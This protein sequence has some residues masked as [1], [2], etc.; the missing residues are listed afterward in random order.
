MGD[1]GVV[2]QHYRVHGGIESCVYSLVAGLNNAGIVP[3]LIGRLNHPDEETGMAR[4]VQERF[5]RSLEFDFQPLWTD[6]LNKGSRF[7]RLTQD[8]SP[9]L[10]MQLPVLRLR[11]VYDFTLPLPLRVARGQYA[12]YWN[13]LPGAEHW[14]LHD[15]DA[16]TGR[17]RRLLEPI[18]ND[19]RRRAFNRGYPIFLNSQFSAEHAIPAVGRR[20]PVLYPPV[21]I[22][23]FWSDDD[24]GRSGIVCFGRFAPYK[25]QMDFVRLAVALSNDGFEEPFIVMGGTETFPGY[26]DEVR[27]A[28]RSLGASNVR[29]VPNPDFET[30]S[31]TL[32]S[33]MIY[34]HMMVNEPFGITA[35]EAVAAGCVPLVHDSGGQREIV[36]M[37]KLRWRDIPELARKIRALA[38]DA[39]DRRRWRSLCQQHV[40]QFSEERFQSALLGLLNRNRYN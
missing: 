18:M 21:S 39:E 4:A 27:E 32:K 13:F 16:G 15:E 10:S 22:P 23:R 5:G 6:R 30:L 17:R 3:R 36:P 1:V 12:K 38:E 40:H 20:L 2:M 28:V 33:S 9:Y 8:P 24:S 26:F 7:T 31:R 11:F 37:E 35:A 29:L 25:R 19:L 34:V 14:S